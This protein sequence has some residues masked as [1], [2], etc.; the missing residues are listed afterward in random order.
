MFTLINVDTVSL[1]NLNR[2]NYDM[3]DISKLKV[4]SLVNRLL[5]INSDITVKCYNKYLTEENMFDIDKNVIG[6]W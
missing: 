1:S 3:R 4:D 5:N 2:Q 6:Y